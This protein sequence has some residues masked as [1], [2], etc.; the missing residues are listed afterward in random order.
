MQQSFRHVDHDRNGVLTLPEIQ[1]ALGM[2]QFRLGN[3]ALIA[4]LESF[5]PLRKGYLD[6]PQYI[7]L[8]AFLTSSRGIFSLFDTNR[9]G[10]I[11]INFDQYCWIAGKLR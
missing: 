7:G 11:Q 3:E 1:T 4:L 10:T 8:A 9:S 5:D 2:N 6:L